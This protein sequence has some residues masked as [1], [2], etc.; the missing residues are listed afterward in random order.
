MCVKVKQH[1]SPWW[2]TILECSAKLYLFNNHSLLLWLGQKKTPN[3]AWN[4][5]FPPLPNT[6]YLHR[7]YCG[8]VADLLVQCETKYVLY[9]PRYRTTKLL[10]RAFCGHGSF[11]KDVCVALLVGLAI[12]EMRGSSR[13]QRGMPDDGEINW[14]LRRQT[15]AECPVARRMSIFHEVI[16]TEVVKTVK[17]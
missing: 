14:C 16:E 10:F 11:S 13:R 7:T 2:I 12:R 17:K 15:H 6:Y 4:S 8:P 5:S 1:W 3:G 9:T